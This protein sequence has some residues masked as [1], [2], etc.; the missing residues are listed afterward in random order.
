MSE[1]PGAVATAEM[2]VVEQST[3]EQEL[4]LG[5]LEPL[6]DEAA[7]PEA[8]T[9]EPTETESEEV[10]GDGRT[11]PQKF[12][13]L[14]KEHK[15]LKNLWFVN[16]EYREQFASP[17][18]AEKAKL[19]ILQLGGDQGIQ[20]I[21]SD[22]AA[23]AQI[24]QRLAQGDPRFVEELAQQNP[25]GFS[26]IVPAALQEF[27]R[28]D[29]DGYNHEMS[30]VFSATFQQRG[31]MADALF[32][33][34]NILQSGNTT[35]AQQIVG[36]LQEWVESWDK[37]AQQKPTK[38][39]N[40]EVEKITKE[41]QQWEQQKLES[42]KQ[43]VGSEVIK[44]IDTGTRR[45]FNTYLKGK[46]LS[47]QAYG[48]MLDSVHKELNKLLKED[49]N[50]Q[51]QAAIHAQKMDKDAALKLHRSRMDKYLPI[52]A[53][54]VYRMFYSNFGAKAAEQKKRV[55]ANQ[56]RKDV[57]SG[58][59]AVAKIAKQPDSKLIDMTRTTR[60]MLWK[61]EAYLKGKKELYK[62]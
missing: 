20:A 50:Y 28:I 59:P 36:N 44:H 32:T 52:A 48:M 41:K 15:E 45:E 26:K 55:E 46:K 27:A 17:S 6:Q 54:S 12:R 16:Q 30:K 58:A 61:N 2:P 29:P 60:D 31:G 7:E 39:A 62:W 37:N 49:T 38:R 1:T 23:L 35:Q 34:Q 14:F 9:G 18:E 22:R 51:K 8:G 33:L 13:Q 25:E 42:W 47:D 5:G 21:E 19:T 24:D 40:P 3:E 43:E 57:G 56:A 10:E 11:I 4:G 53:K